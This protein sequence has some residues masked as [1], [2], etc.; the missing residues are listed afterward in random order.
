MEY[1]RHKHTCFVISPIGDEGTELYQEYKD[2][3]ELIIVPALEVFDFEVRRGDHFVNDDKI[4][5]SVIRNIQDADICI[6][7]ISIPNPNVYYE[8]GRRDET[9]KPILLLKRKGSGQCPVDIATRRYFEYEWE[10]RYAIR[11]AQNHIRTFVEPLVE[12]GFEERGS[13]ATLSDIA[14]CLNRVER[15]LDRLSKAERGSGVLSATAAASI[16]TDNTDPKD[17]FKLALMQK[18][19]PLAEQAMDQL[20]Y[21]ME[22]LSFYDQVVEQVASMGSSR[23][24][25][26]LIE[27]AEEF[28][29][30]NMSFKKKTEYIGSL[31]SYSNK[32]N[33][34]EEVLDLIL[35]L[36]GRLERSADGVEPAQI[37]SIY[38]QQN[39]L[40]YGIY[41]NT[42]DV[43]WLDKAVAAL[44]K[45][46]GISKH[47]FLF[48]N[49]ATC[50][51][52]RFRS[53][54]D[55]E[56]LKAAREAIESCL[57][58]DQKED[59][60]HLELACKIYAKLEDP[61]LGDVFERLAKLDPVA[62]QI[63]ARDLN[64]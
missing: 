1:G 48:Y 27:F 58:R 26:M 25:N 16:P 53:G 37:V 51:F 38:N 32:S 9:G 8:L 35:S 29:D 4:D 22:K 54:G 59:K 12:M 28:F 20:Q 62:A 31:V 47:N 55:T 50:Q 6:C 57:E 10:G 21:R 43:L 60:D 61:K 49:L 24:G 39:R 14:D 23:A 30:S 18:N 17:K 3:F 33:R 45:A 36:C 56:A 41:R 42:N 11:E 7:D 52:A 13:S 5:D 44:Y 19:V 64:I 46:I 40:F 34:E 2:L 63:L 15:K